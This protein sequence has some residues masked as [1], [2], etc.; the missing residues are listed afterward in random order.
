M[1]KLRSAILGQFGKPSG[2]LGA[3]AGLI[4]RV[5]PSNR[6]RSFRTLDLLDLQPGDR[7][8]EIGFGPGLALTRGAELASAGKVIGIDHSE[9]MLSQARRRN[10]KAVKAGRVELFLASAEILP[11]FAE[12]FDKVMAVNVYGFWKDPVRVLTQLLDVMNPGGL[13]A[14]TTQP[15][16]RGATADDA[17][18]AAERMGAAL[19]SAG[20]AE[21]RTE[22]L[23]MT[24]VA[25]ACVLGRK[26]APA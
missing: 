7:L 21:V 6:L 10:A 18:V 16:H 13:I 25:A 4:M 17:R 15:R 9:L 20:F 26:Q 23:E 14:L 19:R 24:P 12:S 5:R 1:S 11:A 2:P 8:L 3:L 22:L